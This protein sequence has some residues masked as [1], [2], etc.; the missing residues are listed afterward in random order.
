MTTVKLSLVIALTI[1]AE[2]TIFLELATSPN[3]R[4]LSSLTMI[5]AS[6]NVFKKKAPKCGG[7]CYSEDSSLELSPRCR[8]PLSQD[9]FS[10]L[11]SFNPNDSFQTQYEDANQFSGSLTGGEDFMSPNSS[12]GRSPWSVKL[13]SATPK[14]APRR[15]VG[16]D[17]TDPNA[18]LL[19]ED[20]ATPKASPWKRRLDRSKEMK[21]KVSPPPIVSSGAM[22]DSSCKMTSTGESN[23]VSPQDATKCRKKGARKSTITM[24]PNVATLVRPTVP[25]SDAGLSKTAPKED[26]DHRSKCK[27]KT[28][29]PTEKFPKSKKGTKK[30]KK[31]SVTDCGPKKVKLHKKELA[32]IKKLKAT[33]KS[34]QEQTTADLNEIRAGVAKERKEIRALAQASKSTTSAKS[35]DRQL[36]KNRATIAQLKTQNADIRE[37][38]KTLQRDITALRVNNERLLSAQAEGAACYNQLK[39]HDDVCVSENAKL[40]KLVE[41]YRVTIEQ[42]QEHLDTCTAHADAES[43]MRS[44][45]EDAMDKTIELLDVGCV[46]DKDL[47]PDVRSMMEA[48]Q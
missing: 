31:S 21:A 36:K 9:S 44:L 22:E 11:G 35:L 19:L 30:S 23:K 26:K 24:V 43:H 8:D 29:A 40:N 42:H 46:G 25:A 38:N 13:K 4:H 37:Q 15:K 3:N 45:Y 28:E 39:Y 12:V 17:W 7:V 27:K 33:L 5:H 10:S 32:Q 2:A 47:V 20:F 16:G 34:I 48:I 18:N 1:V 41:Q 6:T 14:A